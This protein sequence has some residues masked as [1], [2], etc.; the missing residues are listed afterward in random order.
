MAL[1]HQNIERDRQRIS[2]VKPFISQYNWNDIDFTVHQK[3]QEDRE[4]S[5]NWKKFEE[6]NKT[7][8]IKILFAPQNTKTIRLA[9]KSKYNRKRENQVVLLTISDGKK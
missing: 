5:I 6:N 1:N 2:K 8:A 9:Y 7:I 3:D 4:M